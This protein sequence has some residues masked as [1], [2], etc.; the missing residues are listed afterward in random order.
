[1]C[2]RVSGL[3]RPRAHGYEAALAVRVLA[4]HCRFPIIAPNWLFARRPS[5]ENVEGNTGAV[6]GIS[7]GERVGREGPSE[8]RKHE[9]FC[10]ANSGRRAPCARGDLVAQSWRASGDSGAG[11]GDSGRGR[12][13]LD[14]GPAF[15]ALR[16]ARANGPAIRIANSRLKRRHFRVSAEHPMRC[17]WHRITQRDEQGSGTGLLRASRLARRTCQP[18]A[19]ATRLRANRFRSGSGRFYG[20][21]P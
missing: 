1:M 18:L 2:L 15:A 13:L 14:V 19:N 9:R 12:L 8:K 20:R 5:C 7:C 10:E 3:K 17:D 11:A 16:L 6:W 21:V 4:G